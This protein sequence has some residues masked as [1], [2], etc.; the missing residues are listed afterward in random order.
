VSH[1]PIAEGRQGFAVLTVIGGRRQ[2]QL[3]NLCGVAA[4][5]SPVQKGDRGEGGGV[6]IKLLEREKKGR[7]GK[8]GDD[9]DRPLLSSH[10]GAG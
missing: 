6:L 1:S 9:D 3:E 4:V 10:D 2:W 5:Q 8:G 7:D